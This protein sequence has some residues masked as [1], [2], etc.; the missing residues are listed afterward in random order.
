MAVEMDGVEVDWCA[1]CRG[2][3]LDRG[4]LELLHI[5]P[6]AAG[7]FLSDLKAAATVGSESRKCPICRARMAAVE[8][9][10]DRTIVLDRCPKHHGLWFDKG[11]LARV[12]ASHGEDDKV[13]SFLS[14][15]FDGKN[16]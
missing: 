1:G 2:V 15:I 11:E 9:A 3:W 12:L 6:E 10:W 13:K 14:G 8:S 5:H 7:A 16:Q 4:E